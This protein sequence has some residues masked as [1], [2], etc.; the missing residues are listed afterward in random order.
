MQD[1]SGV[2]SPGSF[3]CIDCR[4]DDSILRLQPV[5]VIRNVDVYECYKQAMVSTGWTVK[6]K[7]KIKILTSFGLSR[8]T[9]HCNTD[10]QN[11]ISSSSFC[12]AA[13]PV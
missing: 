2:G 12:I 13:S 5:H 6:K 11:F 1:T 8:Q 9:R 10:L 4:R 3:G 7:K